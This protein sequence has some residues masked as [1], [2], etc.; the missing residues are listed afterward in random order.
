MLGKI[1]KPHGIMILFLICGLLGLNNTYA[2]EGY[3]NNGK[4]KTRNFKYIGE[5]KYY[6]NNGTLSA[7]GFYDENQKQTGLWKLYYQSG[8]LR[9]EI[10]FED[11]NFHGV[12]KLYKENGQFERITNYK[13]GTKEGEERVQ[14]EKPGMWYVKHY[15]N[16]K[17]E[18]ETIQELRIQ[19][20]QASGKVIKTE[21]FQDKQPVQTIIDFPSSVQTTDEKLELVLEEQK[22]AIEQLEATY[23]KTLNLRDT[24]GNKMTVPIS[25]SRDEDRL[26]IGMSDLTLYIP[27]LTVGPLLLQRDDEVQYYIKNSHITDHKYSGVYFFAISSKEGAI[28]IRNTA[29]YLVG[30]VRKEK[31]LNKQ[32]AEEYKKEFD[33][34][35]KE[36]GKM[37]SKDLDK[38]LESYGY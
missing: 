22:Q 9:N 37:L 36:V 21:V 38:L 23:K 34:E 3:Y 17:Q 14:H 2:Q 18:G 35:I 25:I 33:K 1:I 31:E 16:G 15:V 13:Q 28:T 26:R 8:A 27:L 32:K 19:S 10:Q 29:E 6:Y 7:A 5:W 4:G 24:L 30:L 11:G 12:Y 20:Y